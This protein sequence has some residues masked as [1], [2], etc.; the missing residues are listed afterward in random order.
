MTVVGLHGF[1]MYKCVFTHDQVKRSK[2]KLPVSMVE[3]LDEP[4]TICQS[5]L[6][7]S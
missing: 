5:N 2:E 4:G 1:K 7:V 3:L 6:N